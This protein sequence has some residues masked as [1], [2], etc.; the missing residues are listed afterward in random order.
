MQ[1]LKVNLVSKLNKTFLTK[2]I[3]FFFTENQLVMLLVKLDA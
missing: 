1:I 2:F 3:C